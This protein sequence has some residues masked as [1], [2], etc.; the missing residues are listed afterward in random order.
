[1]LGA[2]PGRDNLTS[3][4]AYLIG[5]LGRCDSYS[6]VQLPG[7]DILDECYNAI[8]TAARIVGGNLIV[9]ECRENMFS[10]FYEGQ[11][12][13]KLYDALSEEGLFTL[14]KKVDFK[15]YWNKSY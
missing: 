14:Y 3:I 8:S 4:P 5:Q 11:G 9:L 7:K 15:D 1:M 12:F 13:V 6:S 10:N 2:Y